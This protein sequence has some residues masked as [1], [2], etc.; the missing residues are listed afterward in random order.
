LR[1]SAAPHIRSQR[2]KEIIENKRRKLSKQENVWVFFYFISQTNDEQ[3]GE[4]TC[5]IYRVK[6]GS[7]CEIKSSKR[8]PVYF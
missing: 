2:E 1:R 8:A 4:N 5:S 7:N 3:K 6:G